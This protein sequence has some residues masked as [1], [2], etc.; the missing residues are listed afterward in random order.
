MDEVY[1]LVVAPDGRAYAYKLRS[2]HIGLVPGARAEM[3]VGRAPRQLPT[4]SSAFMGLRLASSAMRNIARCA[5]PATEREANSPRFLA[6]S[7]RPALAK[8]RLEIF[9]RLGVIGEP[10]LSR[11]PFEFAFNAQRDYAQ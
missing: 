5:A 8:C 7:Q 2:G 6:L 10:H 3:K 1:N 4:P 11:V 9:V